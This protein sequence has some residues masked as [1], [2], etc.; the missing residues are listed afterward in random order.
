M[1]TKTPLFIGIAALLSGILLR[2]FTPFALMGLIT[3]VLGVAFK[4]Y[5]VLHAIKTGYYKPGF[6]ILLLII[7]LIMFLFNQALV[8]ENAQILSIVIK[9]TGIGLK[10]SF[11]GMFIFKTRSQIKKSESAN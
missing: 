7:G 9:F 11:V 10:A 3:I 2:L 5:Y 6:E 1:K 8:P 4:L